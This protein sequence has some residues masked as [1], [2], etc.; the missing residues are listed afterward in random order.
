MFWERYGP[1]IKKT[2]YIVVFFLL[3]YISIKYLLPFFAPFVLALILSALNEP[4]IKLLEKLHLSRR[5]GAVIS[6]LFT[7]SVLGTLLTV[8]LVKVYNE[9]TGLQDNLNIY[10]D[11]IIIQVDKFTYKLNTIYNNLPLEITTAISKNIDSISTNIGVWIKNFVSYVINA[12]SSIPHLTVFAIVTLLSTY[13]FSS[14]RQAI[15]SFIYRQLPFKWRK[16][17]VMLKRDTLAAMVGYFKALGMLMSLTFVEVSIGLFI[18]NVKYAL[19]IALVVGLSDAIPI[20]GT[21][22]VM[23]PWILWQL[24]TGNI[25][26]AFGLTIIYILGIL[27]RQILEPKIVGSQIGLPPLVTLIAMYIGLEFFG[28]LGMFIGPITIIIVKNLQD[29]KV[30]KLW[31][32]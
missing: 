29:A 15:S 6:L 7:I 24:I 10:T 18:L 12:M 14:D 9:L 3:L 8:G 32:E 16:S 31:N 25:T 22:V 19:V 30:F 5:I 26:L 27:I 1:I 2:L 11:N 28:I 4:L 21:G 13:F 17:I 23:I 20:V